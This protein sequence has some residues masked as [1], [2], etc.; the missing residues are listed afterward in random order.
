M[1]PSRFGASKFRNA[2]PV[3]PGRD[4]WYRTHLPQASSSNSTSSST[5]TFSS[6]VK[7]S[8]RWIITISPSGEVSW[9]RY[10]ST[11][12]KEGEAGSMKVGSVGDWDISGLE[13]ETL[14]VGG[15]D[16]TVSP[17]LVSCVSSHRQDPEN[18]HQSSDRYVGDCVQTTLDRG[19]PAFRATHLLGRIRHH[20]CVLASDYTV[21]P[22]DRDHPIP[23]GHLR[24]HRL[25]FWTFYR[26]E[27]GGTQGI[28]VMRM[29]A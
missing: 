4:E 2:T 22:P 26:L 18:H 20:K 15:T 28:M 5:S 23:I 21:Y 14:V 11:S 1:P 27:S 9:R 24:S 13:D 10:S 3:I 6:E 19:G 12:G 8:R 16:G 17:Y 29:V 25:P 7:S